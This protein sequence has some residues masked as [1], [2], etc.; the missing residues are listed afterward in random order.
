MLANFDFQERELG[1]SFSRGIIETR[2]TTMTQKSKHNLALHT[3]RTPQL[4]SGSYNQTVDS[5]P[6]CH[7]NLIRSFY[8]QRKLVF[9][10]SANSIQRLKSPK[11]TKFCQNIKNYENV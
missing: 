11:Q 10:Y 5:L 8:L 9:N 6:T 7:V 3:P 4:I 1:T 2:E